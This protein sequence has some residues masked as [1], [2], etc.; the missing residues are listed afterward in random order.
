MRILTSS[1]FSFSPDGRSVVFTDRGP[2]SDGTDAQQ[3]FI[4]D[5]ATGDRKQVTRF[6]AASIGNNPDGIELN[7][8]FVDNDLLGVF[9]FDSV[10][11]TRLFTVRR[12]GSDLQPFEPPIVFPGAHLVPDFRLT[13]ASKQ[14]ASLALDAVTDLPLPG[15]V[16][17]VF[18]RDGKQ[19]LQL[20]KI[21]RSDTQFARRLTGTHRV[22]FASSGDPLGQ[23][24]SNTCQLFTVDRLGGRM[25]QLTHFDPGATSPAGCLGG[26]VGPGCTSVSSGVTQDPRTEALVFD[27]SCDPFGISAVG[28][29]IFA[30]RPDGSGLRQ[31]TAYRGLTIAPDG[32]VDV[33]LPG[34]VAYSAPTL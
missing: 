16:R 28:Q 34:P 18:I 1:G 25:R 20:T 31:I 29:Q 19:V 7:A 30:I 14:V 33:E 2:G 23:N 32:R 12:D 3:L 11:G 5:V 21:G 4:L 27:S 26:A 17:E 6:T 13:G 10:E 22:S 8:V 24:P 15:P 9:V